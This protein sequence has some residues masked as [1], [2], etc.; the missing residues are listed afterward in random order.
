MLESKQF[1]E[2]TSTLKAIKFDDVVPPLEEYRHRAIKLSQKQLSKTIQDAKYLKYARSN[3]ILYNSPVDDLKPFLSKEVSEHT[4]DYTQ[5]Q[6]L[7]SQY[8]SVRYAELMQTDYDAYEY[9]FK[10]DINKFYNEKITENSVGEDVE[11][12]IRSQMLKKLEMD[13]ETHLELIEYCK[14]KNIMFLSTP[15]DIDSINMLVELGIDIIKIPSGEITNLPYLREVARKRKKV[16][17]PL[18]PV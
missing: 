4:I 10:T 3:Y 9:E 6:T 8:I 18:L 1:F 5:I 14:K 17:L 11:Q 12:F 13:K 15:F 2:L 16:I 7:I